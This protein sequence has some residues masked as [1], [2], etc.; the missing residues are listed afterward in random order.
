MS[1]AFS[2]SFLHFL[3]FDA[4]FWITDPGAARKGRARSVCLCGC[5]GLLA[6]PTPFSLVR[7]FFASLG[8]KDLPGVTAVSPQ[9]TG[10]FL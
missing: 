4:L 5:L 9:A 2:S 8:R 6:S 10:V 1:L 7:L 3:T